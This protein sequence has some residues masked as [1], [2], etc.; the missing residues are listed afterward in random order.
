MR[1]WVDL[2][3][4]RRRRARLW[5][6]GFQFGDWLDP[7]APP[8]KPGR[9]ADR[10]AYLVA[11]AYFAR[12]AELVGQAAGVL[13]RAEDEAHYLALAAEVRAAFADEYVTPA[14]RLISDAATAYALALAVRPAAR[15]RAAPARRR[16]PGRAGP[17]RAATAS[18]PASSARR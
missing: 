17:R 18:A 6:K 9:G 13:G 2:V 10:P 14:G 3:A 12:S 16:A 7:T 5:D 4:E 8:D 15:R 11:T 1:A